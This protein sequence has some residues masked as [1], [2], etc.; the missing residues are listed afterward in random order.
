M[1]TETATA[2]KVDTDRWTRWVDCV[3]DFAFP[4]RVV[5]NKRLIKTNK[6]SQVPPP[7]LS[8]SGNA[9]KTKGTGIKTPAEDP[10]AKSTRTNGSGIAYIRRVGSADHIQR[11]RLRA[12]FDDSVLPPFCQ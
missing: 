4:V 2:A 5:R 10:E 6:D 7:P 1:A 8:Q 3:F 9:R 11:R 12:A